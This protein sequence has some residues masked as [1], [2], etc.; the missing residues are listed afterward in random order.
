MSNM[1]PGTYVQESNFPTFTTNS[2]TDT[3]SMFVGAHNR[4]PTTPVLIQGWAQFVALY[5]G[6]VLGQTP[7]NLALAVYEFFNNGGGQCYVIRVV[8]SDATAA[9]VP[10]DGS[11]GDA[12]L[13]AT[14]V[15]P[16]AWGDN[17]YVVASTYG[18]SNSGRFNLAVYYG[19]TGQ[20]NLAEPLWTNLSMDPADSRYAP[21]IINGLSGSNFIRLTDQNSPAGASSPVPV[22]A[23][24]AQ[25]GTGSGSTP[26]ADGSTVVAAD[27]VAVTSLMDTIPNPLL[28]NFPGETDVT[29]VLAPINGY[30]TGQRAWPDSVLFVD[31]ASGQTPA[32]A[33]TYAE[34]C[35]TSSYMAVYYP[36]VQVSDP[37]SNV[38]GATRMVAPSAFV[39]GYISSNDATNGVQKAPAGMSA[40]LAALGPE[41]ALSTAD[42]GNLNAAHVNSIVFMQ[43]TG[44]VIWGARTLSNIQNTLYLNVRRVLIYVE[45]NLKSLAQY[46][47]FESNN[48]ILWQ[49]L[50]TRFYSFLSRFWASG[51]LSGTTA[52][53]AFYITCDETNNS[54]N[55]GTTV[56][57]VGVA[58][59]DPAEFVIIKVGQWEGG[60]TVT[61]QT[62]A[63]SA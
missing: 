28:I 21:T 39:M 20:N 2:P 43:G 1:A 63:L 60:T 53:Q 14:A 36:Y 23:S 19:G 49:Q 56:A 38:P 51:G 33:I 54:S 18:A 25:L 12:T 6:F 34:T 40:T 17:I 55:S 4:G 41:R 57:E 48:Y 61:E 31:T 32:A 11:G 45:A 27:K 5:G 52:A 47:V 3:L 26:G 16:G 44:T 59:S 13:L 62:A 29:N 10:L 42:V 58:P 37:A 9:A 7:S 35:P 24:P 30:I 22:T 15:N 46:A 50:T 8:H